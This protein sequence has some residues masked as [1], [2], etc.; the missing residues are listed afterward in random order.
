MPDVPE[1]LRAALTERYA[2]QRPL[3][4]GGMA[5][6]YL[7]R[8]LKHG[9]DVAV[10]VMHRELAAS[11]AAERFLQEIQIAARL[12]HPHILVLIDSGQADDLLYFVMPY[13]P[14][15]S[16][17]ARLLREKRL[18]A[19]ATLPVVREVADALAYA[20]RQGIVHRDIKPE[21]VLLSEGHA[22]V[23]DF[24]IAKALLSAGGQ[25][26]T[27]TGY[28]VG[29]PGYMSP[30]QAAGR[31][32]LDARTD[33]FSLACV[34]Y[35]LLVGE[36]PGMWLEEEAVRLRRFVDAS[37]SHRAL[38]DQFPGGVEQALLRYVCL[39]GSR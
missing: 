23:T 20:H 21:N 32:D 14:G 4:R 29:T 15:E 35:E 9:R 36:T 27:R 39:V 7:A 22:V 2:L 30:E 37:P 24:G 10:K 12:T 8:D 34:A 16:L 11:L 13:V 33:V 31:S 5:V 3:G 26:L 25:E 38:L 17:R 6:V 18:G 1:D 28:P 19:D